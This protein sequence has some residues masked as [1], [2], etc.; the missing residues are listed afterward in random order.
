MEGS[1][2]HIYILSRISDCRRLEMWQRFSLIECWDSEVWQQV[3]S[4]S[5]FLGLGSLATS[6]F[7]FKILL[8][9]FNLEAMAEMCHG[10]QS[11]Q[12]MPIKGL[13]H[14]LPQRNSADE[15]LRINVKAVPN[16]W[17]C[18]RHGKEAQKTS[19]NDK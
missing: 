12:V 1:R 14:L 19:E 6:A 15:E 11:A 10:K 5:K 2:C 7:F 13:A 16:T 3:P 4:F 17:A 8:Q 18:V 9:A